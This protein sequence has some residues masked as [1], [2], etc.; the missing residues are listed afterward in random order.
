[1]GP[2]DLDEPQVRVDGLAELLRELIADG[3][4]GSI[5][6]IG[7]IQ[8]ARILPGRTHYAPSKL[9]VEGMTRNISDEM[10]PTVSESTAST[11]A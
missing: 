4:K 11:L 5:I 8:A 9:A 2:G 1:M 3:A 6:N 7:S 10:A